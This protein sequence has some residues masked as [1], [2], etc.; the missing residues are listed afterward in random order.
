MNEDFSS[1]LNIDLPRKKPEVDDI[2][3]ASGARYPVLKFVA[4]LYRF[5]GWIMVG[6]SVLAF[7]FS[8]YFMG[9]EGAKA[10]IMVLY[11][12][13][14]GLLVALSCFFVAES[15]MV[16]TH[17]EENTRMTNELLKELVN[18]KSDDNPKL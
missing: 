4:K 15:M 5:A 7:F 13:I 9:Q 10:G 18:P 14:I 16:L 1:A 8:M 2:R 3:T 6:V 11:A 17:I 12:V